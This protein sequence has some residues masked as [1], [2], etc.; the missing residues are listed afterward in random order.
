[1]NNV[2]WGTTDNDLEVYFGRVGEVKSATIR[3]SKSGRSQ[4]QGTVEFVNAS[5]AQDAIERLN[6]TE[7]DGRQIS[8]RAYYETA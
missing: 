8:V 6:N 3:K 7:L 4:G 1:M 2:S 5:D